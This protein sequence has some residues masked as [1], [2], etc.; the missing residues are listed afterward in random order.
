M[1]TIAILASPAGPA[2]EVEGDGPLI[3]LCDE[4]RA[5]VAFS[6][7]AASCGTCRVEVLAGAGLLE[8]PGR[9]EI[10]LLASPAQRLACQ[11]VVRPGP[12]LV[13][14]RWIGP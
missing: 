7:R 13:R 2:M 1:P 14:L 9:D 8:P 5:P 6:C 4:A 11:A 3:D 10:P 12:G